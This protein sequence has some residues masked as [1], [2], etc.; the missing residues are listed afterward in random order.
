MEATLYYE[1]NKENKDFTK[2]MLR[3]L[4]NNLWLYI[5][6]I[7]LIVL[8]VIP[9]YEMEKTLMIVS[10]LVV[11]GF[12]DL[13]VLRR[14]T[15]YLNQIKVEDQMV[16]FSVMRYNQIYLSSENHISNVDLIREYHPFRL[17]IKENGEVVHQQYALGFWSR[18]KLEELYQKFH[19]LKQ[20][21]S[22]DSMFKRNL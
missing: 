3:F 14:S 17:V 21:V 20:G 22:M 9:P 2:R 12:R 16:S 1:L 8:L 5:P 18:E 19:N 11:L 4:K 6:D 7:A 13:V 10:G 15:Y